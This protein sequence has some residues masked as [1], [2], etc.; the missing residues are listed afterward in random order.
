MSTTTTLPVMAKGTSGLVRPLFK[1]GLLLEDEDLTAIVDYSS[2]MTR[3]LFS[4]LFGCG[5]VCG[6]K[7]SARATCKGQKLEITIGKGLGLDCAGNPIHVTSVQTLTYDPECESFPGRIWITACYTTDYCRPRNAACSDDDDPQAVKTRMR[8][9]FELHL[10]SAV[11]EHAC[12]CVGE[13]SEDECGCGCGECGECILIGELDV[14]SAWF[15]ST[16]KHLRND[17]HFDADDSNVRKLRRALQNPCRKQ[18]A[19]DVSSVRD[20]TQEVG[21]ATGEPSGEKMLLSAG[22]VKQREKERAGL[23][24]SWEPEYQARKLGRFSSA[25]TTSPDC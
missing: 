17:A 16:A 19:G 18:T 13:S 2:T 11:P 20:G 22:E 3:L 21:G 4:S 5:I 14:K 9:G 6:L 15:D 1:P 12:S 24:E 7:I 25:S 8:E 10:H 23:R